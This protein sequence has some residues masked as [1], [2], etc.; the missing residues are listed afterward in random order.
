M[1]LVN[2]ER[3]G[4]VVTLTL[5]RPEKLNAFS[6]EL[7]GA[8][9]EEL[10]R[11]DIDDEAQIAIL[12]GNGRAFSSGADVQQRLD[13]FAPHSSCTGSAAAAGRATRISQSMVT[14]GCHSLH[15]EDSLAPCNVPPT[16]CTI[17]IRGRTHL[18]AGFTNAAARNRSRQIRI[19]SKSRLVNHI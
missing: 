15:G 18:A 7:V 8:L 16:A 17:Q 1:A 19:C 6:D 13:Q 3:D 11:F 9:G 10:Y 12:C 5:N 2:Y 14:P 4:Q